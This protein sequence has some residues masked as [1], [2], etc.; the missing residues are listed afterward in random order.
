M[1]LLR[2]FKIKSLKM[3]LWHIASNETMQWKKVQDINNN[4]TSM[5]F[6][7]RDFFM[8]DTPAKS[9][10]KSQNYAPV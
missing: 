2:I 4:L 5:L 7:R 10:W 9:F 6:P 1:H 3:R 8:L